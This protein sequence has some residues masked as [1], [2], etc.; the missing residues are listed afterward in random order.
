L[1]HRGYGE[2]IRKKYIEYLEDGT[3]DKPGEFAG[4]TETI[5]NKIAIKYFCCFLDRGNYDYAP[6][7]F[8]KRLFLTYEKM[9]VDDVRKLLDDVAIAFDR[10]IDE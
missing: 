9:N 1:F 6:A 7:I 5:G 3:I 8:E 2:L 4:P 10:T